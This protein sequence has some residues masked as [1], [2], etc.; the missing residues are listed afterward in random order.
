MKQCQEIKQNYIGRENFDI[1]F[2]CKYQSFIFGK[3]ARHYALP[4][5]IFEIF[6]I[7]LI[8]PDLKSYGVWQLAKQLENKVFCTRY[9]VPLSLCFLFLVCSFFSSCT[10]FTEIPRYKND[11]RFSSVTLHWIK[12]YQ[13]QTNVSWVA[14]QYLGV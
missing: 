1:C 2:C 8:S 14:K 10:H 9:H 3:E 13:C 6:F 4:P 5:P 12:K 7:F 11:K